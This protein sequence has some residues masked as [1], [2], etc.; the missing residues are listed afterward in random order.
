MTGEA[1]LKKSETFYVTA[2][3]AKMLE[4]AHELVVHTVFKKFPYADWVLKVPGNKVQASF[5]RT[6]QGLSR[7]EDAYFVQTGVF[8]PRH[9]ALRPNIKKLED[10]HAS[11]RYFFRQ[12]PVRGLFISIF[13]R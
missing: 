13:F 10:W 8:N 12:L 3:Y 7:L 6:I 11:C 9:K 4:M 5:R 2:I 1:S